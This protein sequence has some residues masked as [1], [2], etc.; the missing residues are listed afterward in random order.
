M[1]EGGLRLRFRACQQLSPP[2][3]CCPPQAPECYKSN[4]PRLQ[5]GY[6][7]KFQQDTLFYIFYSAPCDEAQLFAADEL[8]NRGWWFH[9]VPARMRVLL[10]DGPFPSTLKSAR[11]TD[12]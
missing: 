7:T 11:M 1:T 5:A 10:V 8:A 6:F 12:L 4:P 3:G 2:C 9:K